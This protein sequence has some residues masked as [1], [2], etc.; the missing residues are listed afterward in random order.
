M[1]VYV[2]GKYGFGFLIV[3]LFC[4]V[5]FVVG[6]MGGGDVKLISFIGLWFGFL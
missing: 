6:W 4:F 1:F 3:F 2:W 5:F